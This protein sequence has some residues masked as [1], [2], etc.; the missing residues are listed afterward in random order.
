MLGQMESQLIP[1]GVSYFGLVRTT[2]DDRF[3]QLS[4]SLVISGLFVYK[5]RAGCDAQLIKFTRVA[6][7]KRLATGS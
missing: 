4:L 3:R 6:E 2:L 1:F 5:W 7:L